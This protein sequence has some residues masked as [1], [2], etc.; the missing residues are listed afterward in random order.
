[1]VYCIS[2]LHGDIEKF[3]AML[4]R[5]H[6]RDEDTLYVLGDV[7]DR[8]PNGVEILKIIMNAA[9]IHMLLGN[10]EQMCI[11][12]LGPLNVLGARSL[13]EQNGGHSTFQELVHFC[14]AE[15]KNGIIAFLMNLP[16]FIEIEVEGQ[17]FHLVHG[18]PGN[19]VNDRL[20]GRPDFDLV[21]GP[22][23]E[24]IV[25]IGHTP[26]NYLQE[27]NS[28]HYEIW[29]RP[30]IIDIDCGCGHNDPKCRLAC[31]YLN[32]MDVFYI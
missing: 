31:L 25:I 9:N 11:A 29:C 15:E 1:M 17:K 21:A 2:D 30:G 19:T 8:K 22:L 24:Q 32:T 12:T 7:I 3:Q 18:Y 5:I 4:K 14:T 16:T 20:W 10:H 26:T 28:T 6:F 27:T 13:W 23:E